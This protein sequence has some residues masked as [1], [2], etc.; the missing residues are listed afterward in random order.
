MVR[1]S[2]EKIRLIGRDTADVAYTYDSIE[3]HFQ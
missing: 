1:H 2:F 3:A